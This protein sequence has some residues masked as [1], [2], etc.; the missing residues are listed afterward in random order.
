M[1]EREQKAI[2]FGG[3]EFD[4][5][6]AVRAP[7]ALDPVGA[8]ARRRFATPVC[9]VRF[10]SMLRVFLVFDSGTAGLLSPLRR[11]SESNT[12]YTSSSL[13]SMTDSRAFGRRPGNTVWDCPARCA[14]VRLEDF[15]VLV[16]R[17]VV[18]DS[19]LPGPR[20]VQQIV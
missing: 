16:L 3:I 17:G 5:N 15:L 20:E 6:F 19:S 10:D 4:R 13:S 11:R 1:L 14:R 18:M 7:V 2:R 9:G 12:P 8:H